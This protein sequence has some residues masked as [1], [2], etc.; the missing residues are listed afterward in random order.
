[1]SAPGEVGPI[2]DMPAEQIVRAA[3]MIRQGRLISL[4][5][6]RFDGMPLFPGHPPFQV[7]NAVSPRGI[8]AGRRQPWGP[9][10]DIGLGY[11]A[12]YLMCTSHSG[13]H[14]DALAHM[15]VGEDMHWYGGGR[16][17]EHLTDHGPIF[18]D[19][20]QHAAHVHP[21][22]APRRARLPRR[23]A[24]RRGEPVGAA[25]LQDICRAQ[26]VEVRRWD[27]VAHPHRLHEPLA[28]LRAR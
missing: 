3:A 16:A 25:E 19:A 12:E 23:A 14:I 22:R 7:L 6:T 1:M 28:G 20:S 26:G 24:P 9:V 21:R 27:V 4:A 2:R 15:T 18:G 17:D 5:A 11:M 10:N 13:A 8:R